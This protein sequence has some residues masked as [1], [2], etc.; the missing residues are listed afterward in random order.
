MLIQHNEDLTLKLADER[1]KYD[2]LL[3]DRLILDEK[4][5]LMKD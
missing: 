3:H 1:K 4:L 5:R 2:S